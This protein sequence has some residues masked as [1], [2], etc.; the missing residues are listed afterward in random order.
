MVRQAPAAPPSP[1]RTSG[2]ADGAEGV[3]ARAVEMAESIESLRVEYIRML[4]E[5][6]Q[7]EPGSPGKFEPDVLDRI[8]RLLGFGSTAEQED[9]Q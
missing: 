7:P 4:V 3:G 1:P 8:E 2:G 6:V 9:P 5:S